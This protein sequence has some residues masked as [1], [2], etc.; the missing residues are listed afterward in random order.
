MTNSQEIFV[1]AL[2][3]QEPWRKTALGNKYAWNNIHFYRIFV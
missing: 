1:I 2:G 3:L